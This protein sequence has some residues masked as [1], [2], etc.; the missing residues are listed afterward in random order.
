MSYSPSSRA[1]GI[2]PLLG[3]EVHLVTVCLAQL[4]HHQLGG[5]IE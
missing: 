5:F 3:G 4:W 2:A 1:G